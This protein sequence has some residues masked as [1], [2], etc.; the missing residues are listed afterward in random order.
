MIEKQRF[1]KGLSIND[2][3][4]LDGRGYK[5]FWDKIVIESVTMEKGVSKMIQNCLM[6]FMD[7]PSKNF[8]TYFVSILFGDRFNRMVMVEFVLDG[9]F[10]P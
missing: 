3:T 7:D 8:K 6:S 9:S 2:V 10:L 1:V 4:A 5:E